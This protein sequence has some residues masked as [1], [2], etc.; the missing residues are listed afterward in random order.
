MFMG[1]AWVL[2]S[3]LRIVLQWMFLNWPLHWRS[4]RIQNQW[5]VLHKKNKVFLSCASG[6]WIRMNCLLVASNC[7]CG[8]KNQNKA[9]ML[10][11]SFARLMRHFLLTELANTRHLCGSFSA[12]WCHSVPVL[13]EEI[14]HHWRAIRVQFN[15]TANIT[16]AI[17]QDCILTLLSN[18]EIL[19]RHLRILPKEYHKASLE[20]IC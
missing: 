8:L 14:P 15:S 10:I 5:V 12:C 7:V 4:T 11:L 1:R 18:M 16:F 3:A 13:T 17:C 20:V 2:Q 19:F 6:K 9:S